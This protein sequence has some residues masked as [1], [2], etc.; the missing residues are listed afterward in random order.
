MTTAITTMIG[1]AAL[2]QRGVVPSAGVKWDSD[3]STASWAP[4][5]Y[6]PPPDAARRSAFA[7]GPK[8]RSITEVR[9]TKAKASTDKRSGV[10]G[11]V[12]HDLRRTCRTGL[13]R[14]KVPEIVAERCLNHAPKGLSGIYN[15]HEYQDEKAEAFQSWADELRTI[16]APPPNLV[17][18]ESA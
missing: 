6:S 10:T 4:G 9:N 11:W 5:R 14:L 13:A 3:V 18:L 7:I 2:Y 1:R 15:V 12:I 8:S 17:R 16:V